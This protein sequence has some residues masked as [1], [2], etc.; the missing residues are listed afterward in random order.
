MEK[1]IIVYG[2]DWCPDCRRTRA[3]LK[4]HEVAYED[5]NIEENP[6]AAETVKRINGGN[7]SIPT[8]V[9]PDGSILVEPSNN[10]LAEKLGISLNR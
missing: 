6:E 5:V 4:R 9:F 7:R 2:A 8:I 1:N 10:E 3:F